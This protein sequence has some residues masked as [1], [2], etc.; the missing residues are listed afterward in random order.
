MLGGALLERQPAPQVPGA[1]SLGIPEA[2]I[3]ALDYSHVPPLSVGC[4]PYVSDW[5]GDLGRAE[6][7]GPCGGR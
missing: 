4:G 2:S 7:K 1:V 3:L 6:P 5:T